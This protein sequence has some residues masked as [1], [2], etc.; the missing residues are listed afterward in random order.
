MLLPIPVEMVCETKVRY[1]EPAHEAIVQKLAALNSGM[2]TDELAEI[3]QVIEELKKATSYG[4][5]YL[6]KE[7][8]KAPRTIEI[9]PETKRFYIHLKTH[10]MPRLGRGYHKRV[11]YSILYDT[12]NPKLVANATVSDSRTTRAE[13]ALLEKF[14]GTDGIVGL[15]HSSKHTKTTGKELRALITPL[16][17]RG[18]LMSL[19]TK[20]SRSLTIEAKFKI[21]KDILTGSTKL[22]ERGYI[23]RDNNKGNFFVHEEDGTFSAVIGDLGGY[24]HTLKDALKLRPLGPNLRS[25]PPD[26]QKA[27]YEN[28]LTE[29]DLLSLHVYSVARTLHY[30]LFE[31]DLPWS[32]TF[33]RKYPLLAK[34]YKDK[35][36]PDVLTQIASFQE[37]VD[38]YTKPRI[39]KLS[40][41]ATLTAH[42]RFEYYLMQMLSS[43]PELR[44]TNS[45]WLK[46][47]EEV[48]KE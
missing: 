24:T 10:N 45:H 47:F 32:D 27:Y 6:R 3:V 39:L 30:L 16:Y 38:G 35:S 21:A 14:K 46:K 34:L 5:L 42:E 19:I 28:R 44:K 11:T 18:S 37:V 17:N 29:E 33:D 1:R 41:K 13:I 25:S 7:F 36:N 15:L 4:S 8:T 22:N 23:N 2:T 20:H 40:Q 9:D 12:N 43:D 48:Y 26:L 31:R